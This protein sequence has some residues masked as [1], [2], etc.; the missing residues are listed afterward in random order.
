MTQ[1]LLND[2]DSLLDTCDSEYESI[3]EYQLFTG[4]LSEQTVVENN[5]RRLKTK[6]DG[7][8]NSSALQNPLDPDT[9]YRNKGGK[10]HHG[11]VA[12]FEEPVILITYGGYDGQENIALAKEKN[13]VLVTTA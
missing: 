6:E 2:G 10:S 9:T 5:K 12:N 4:C 3:T 1:K 11:Y 7:T 13:V 8:M